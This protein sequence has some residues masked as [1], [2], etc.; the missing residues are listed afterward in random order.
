MAGVAF[1]LRPAEAGDAKAI[2]E[3]HVAVWRAT[4][5]ALAPEHCYR[6]LDVPYRL[7]HW[8]EILA[9]P[10]AD[11]TVLVAECQDRLAGFGMCGA[12]GHPAFDGRGEI[13]HLHVGQDWKRRGLGRQLLAAMACALRDFGHSGIALGVVAENLP[14]RAFYEAMGGAQIGAYT[15]PGPHWRS[16]NLIYAWSDLDTLLHNTGHQSG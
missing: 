15:D 16:H 10:K 6:I 5:A 2:A 1:R 3:M 4:Y 14:A 11:R 12:P 8:R 9:A 7:A 13:K